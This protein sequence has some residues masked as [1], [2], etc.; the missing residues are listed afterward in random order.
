ME[1]LQTFNVY[2]E[3]LDTIRKNNYYGRPLVLRHFRI[4]FK[5]FNEEDIVLLKSFLKDN[6]KKWFVAHLLDNLDTF[7]ND[8]LEP[9]LQAA[10]NETDPSFNND[11][12]KPCRRVFDYAEIQNILLEIFCN[13]D[14]DKK[15]GVLKALYWA[16]PKVHSVEVHEGKK[17]YKQQGYDTFFWDYELNS[18]DEDFTEDQKVYESEYPR[19]EIAYKRQLETILAEFHKTTD[20]DL[21]YQ[22]TLQLP[23]EVKDFPEELQK[24][25]NTF[26]LDKVKQGIPNNISELEQV[27]NIDNSFLRRIVLKVKSFFVKDKGISLKN[28]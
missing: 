6:N 19:Q 9:M 23:S 7:P 17:I 24:V 13:G 25:A 10:V 26:L 16:R 14:N 3:Q 2:Q 18:F 15:K 11:F 21:K 27:Q 28:H 22:I 5:S 1:I 12:I 4:E 8:L 20:K